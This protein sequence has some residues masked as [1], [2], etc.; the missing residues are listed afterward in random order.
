MGEAK[1]PDFAH[2]AP[3]K[4]KTQG[5]LLNEKYKQNPEATQILRLDFWR[6]V[7]YKIS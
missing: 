7:L 5:R 6:Y 2:C 3:G 1:D 4:E